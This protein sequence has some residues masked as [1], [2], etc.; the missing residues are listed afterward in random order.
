MPYGNPGLRMGDECD[1]CRRNEGELGRLRPVLNYRESA[2]GVRPEPILERLACSR[3]CRS[4]EAADRGK[5]LIELRKA[6]LPKFKNPRK[7]PK[8]CPTCKTQLLVANT[9]QCTCGRLTGPTVHFLVC[10]VCNC[11]A[12]VSKY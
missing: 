2:I 5:S 4:Y 11:V 3:C 8:E 6:Q 7:R 1:D 12:W 10:G 9:N